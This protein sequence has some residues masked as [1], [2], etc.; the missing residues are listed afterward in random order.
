KYGDLR[1]KS[2]IIG[3]YETAC[4]YY[5]KQTLKGGKNIDRKSAFVTHVSCSVKML[6]EIT[7]EVNSCCQFDELTITDASA[8]ISSNCGPGTFGVLFVKK[9]QTGS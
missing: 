7:E 4:R 5:V 3:S 6:R 2:V 1:R 8:T 9:K